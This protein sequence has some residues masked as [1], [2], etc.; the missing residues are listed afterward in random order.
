MLFYFAMIEEVQMVIL[1]ICQLVHCSLNPCDSYYNQILI[2]VQYQITSN[3]QILKSVYIS[4]IK[5]NTPKMCI[6]RFYMHK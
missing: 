1:P 5:K 4:K 6:S 2:C 3:L